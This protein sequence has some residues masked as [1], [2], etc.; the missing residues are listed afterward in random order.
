M[1]RVAHVR[2][3]RIAVYRS[4]RAKWPMQMLGRHDERGTQRAFLV[5]ATWRDWREQRSPSFMK[6]TR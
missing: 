1:S 5:R 6:C 3:R 2:V 4:A